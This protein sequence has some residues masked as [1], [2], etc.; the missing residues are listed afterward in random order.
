MAESFQN[1]LPLRHRLLLTIVRRRKTRRQ[2]GLQDVASGRNLLLRDCDVCI[3]LYILYCIYEE[4][5]S[6]SQTQLSGQ[7]SARTRE[8]ER[9][10]NVR[11]SFLWRICRCLYTISRVHTYIGYSEIKN[12]D[13]QSINQ[14]KQS[15]ILALCVCVF[16]S[17]T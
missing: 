12:E 3:V 6:I 11:G 13:H 7:G 2:N 8:R 16:L 4:D 15:T 10:I 1:L 17:V 9:E 5:Y 14:S